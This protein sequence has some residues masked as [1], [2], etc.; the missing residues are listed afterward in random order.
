M[1][2]QGTFQFS[3]T[4]LQ[5]YSLNT[6]CLFS[7][8]LFVFVLFLFLFL[9][10]FGLSSS[11]LFRMSPCSRWSELVDALK[12]HANLAFS[13]NIPTEFRFLNSSAPLKIGYGDAKKN[14]Q[15]L[16]QFMRICDGSPN[17]AT[18]LCRHIHEITMEI[19]QLEGQLL[20]NG[21]IACVV[22]A[23]DGEASDGNIVEALR[24]L[25]QLPVMIVLRLCTDEEKVVQY[26]NSVEADVEGRLDV[27]DDLA[28]EA[29][30]VTEVNGWLTYGEPLHRMREFGVTMK[31]L[32]MLDEQLLSVESFKRVCELILGVDMVR[33]LTP[34]E[35]DMGAFLQ[36]L[37]SEMGGAAMYQTWCPQ[38]NLM[39]PWISIAEARSLY[40]VSGASGG[41]SIC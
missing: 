40:K 12:F 10:F 27:L 17:G 11:P 25:K 22:I 38:R 33:K 29:E 41:G 8:V 20:A 35:M 39:R 36:E 3:H 23:T 32:D 21:Q 19:R 34:P 24:P 7:P 30:E 5:L 1:E 14:R 13:G 31:D 28:G 4:N 18:P 6:K 2:N 16:D 37:E 9:F 26:W 15:N